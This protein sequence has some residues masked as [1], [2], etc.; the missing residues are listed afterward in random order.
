MTIWTVER[1][2]VGWSV[3][4]YRDGER[5]PV[6]RSFYG[7]ACITAKV[8]RSELEQAYAAGWEVARADI[9]RAMVD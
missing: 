9:G 4:Q 5:L 7:L 6:R 1:D 2:K 3:V 8:I